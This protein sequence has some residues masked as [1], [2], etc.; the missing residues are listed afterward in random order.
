[1]QMV[2][3]WSVCVCVCVCEFVLLRLQGCAVCRWWECGVCVSVCE[4]VCVCVCGTH[5]AVLYVD[6]GN[7]CV[8]VCVCVT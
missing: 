7:V 4:C 1:M 3:M 8:C 2:G 6:G 5:R